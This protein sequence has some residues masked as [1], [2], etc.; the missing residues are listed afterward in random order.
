MRDS[1][2][3]AL[4]GGLLVLSVLSCDAGDDAG[5]CSSQAAGCDPFEFEVTQEDLGQVLAAGKAPDGTYYVV[6]APN[7]GS[8]DDERVFVSEGGALVRKDVRGSTYSGGESGADKMVLTYG[9]GDSLPALYVLAARDGSSEMWW[10]S[11]DVDTDW[12]PERPNAECTALESV[13][14]SQLSGMSVQG[15][16]STKDI[17]YFA[18]VEGGSY[19]LVTVPTYDWSY[20]DFE[21]WYGVPGDMQQKEVLDVQRLT[22]GGSTFITFRMCPGNAVVFFNNSMLM[23]G[24]GSDWSGCYLEVDGAKTEVSRLETKTFEQ[25]EFKFSCH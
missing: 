15:L 10:C 4:F 1:G 18:Q 7:E 24:E 2:S 8:D 16:P 11:E 6:A 14:A 3:L 20:E 17:E 5:T 23:D 12:V 21:L 13:D 19:L 25:E 22:D 9:D